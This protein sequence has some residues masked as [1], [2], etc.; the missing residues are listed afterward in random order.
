MKFIASIIVLVASSTAVLMSSVYGDTVSTNTR[1]PHAFWRYVNKGGDIKR[2]SDQFVRQQWVHLGSWAIPDVKGASGAGIHDVYTERWVL[3]AF[4]DTHQ[5]PDG[6]VLVKQVHA[7]NNGSRATGPVAYWEGQTGV[8]FVMVKDNKNRFPKDPRWGE[9]W[10]WALFKADKPD[11][12]LSTT[13]KGTGL[14]NCF[15]CHLPAKNTDWTYLE[16]YPVLDL[17]AEQKN[18]ASAR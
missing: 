10:G 14:N 8:W 18:N 6:A 13:W 7:I 2:P 3:K 4:N 11:K 15:G 17:T 1:D 16:G 9:G 5:W 12:N